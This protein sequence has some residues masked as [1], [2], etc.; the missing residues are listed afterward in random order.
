MIDEVVAHN[1]AV[2]MAPGFEHEFCMGALWAA[3]QLQARVNKMKSA[4]ESL[5]GIEA[6]IADHEMKTYFQ[7]TVYDALAE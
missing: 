3:E 7:K 5:R 4:L 6:W 2:K 1:H